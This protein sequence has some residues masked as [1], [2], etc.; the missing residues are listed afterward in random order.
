M[1]EDIVSRGG[2]VLSCGDVV[3]VGVPSSGG[4]FACLCS[5]DCV[6]VRAVDS[7]TEV[8]ERRGDFK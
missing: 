7:V 4:G 5:V 3:R 8:L 1:V 6:I 2:I